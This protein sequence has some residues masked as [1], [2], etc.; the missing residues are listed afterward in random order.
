VG[1]VG[2]DI[3]QL[4]GVGRAGQSVHFPSLPRGG[5]PDGPEMPQD[6]AGSGGAR[7]G[8]PLNAASIGKRN[9]HAASLRSGGIERD[10]LHAV[11]K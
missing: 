6:I 10:A 2:A 5:N 4:H 7:T 1:E 9:R 8:F 3:D 11:R